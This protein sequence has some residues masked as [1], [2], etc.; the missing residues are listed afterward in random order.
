VA[1]SAACHVGVGEDASQG[2][3]GVA[4]FGWDRGAF[5]CTFG[6]NASEGIP[7][8]AHADLLVLNAA[9]L[10]EF[11]VA[12]DSEPIASFELVS[13]G[14]IRVDAH[15]AGTAR[16]ELTD[17]ATG[18]LIDRFAIHVRDVADIELAIEDL[19]EEELTI[20]SGGELRIDLIL[21]DDSGDALIGIGG[22]TYAASGEVAGAALTLVDAA[23]EAI[24]EALFGASEYVRLRASAAGAGEVE[25]RAVS[26]VA[27][28]LP[29]RIIDADAVTRVIIA[30]P[31]QPF[32]VGSSTTLVASALAGTEPAHSPPCAWTAPETGPIVASLLGR[33]TITLE[34]TAAGQATV[35]CAVGDAEAS[36]TV[37]ATPP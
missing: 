27:L 28:E 25:V 35:R 7:A 30:P 23:T 37:D 6:C 24:L 21:R 17:T 3:K 2:E 29:I 14:R 13:P 20:V 15:T 33:S 16:V 5:G 12:S 36:I 11:A 10:P 19:Y 32:R 1:A 22:V 34:A 18:D 8:E 9:D 4:E 26:G 31:E